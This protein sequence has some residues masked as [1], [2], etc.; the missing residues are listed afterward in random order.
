M[1]FDNLITQS[2]FESLSLE[3]KDALE[4]LNIGVVKETYGDKLHIGGEAWFDGKGIYMMINGK[5]LYELN[6]T[7]KDGF[8]YFRPR[9]RNFIYIGNCNDWKFNW[10]W[11]IFFK[12]WST[13][14]WIWEDGK[15]VSWRKYENGNKV[16]CDDEKIKK[17]VNGR[18]EAEMKR[19]KDEVARRNVTQ[20]NDGQPTQPKVDRVVQGSQV[21]VVS[22]KG[23]EDADPKTD[24]AQKIEDSGELETWDVEEIDKSTFDVLCKGTSLTLTQIKQVVWYANKNS[25]WWLF[26]NGLTSINEWMARELAKFQWYNLMLN[27]LT[28][29]DVD[30]AA[31]LSNFQ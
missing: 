13:Y 25:E 20:G 29:I 15:I 18:I 21:T 16:D 4:E 27:S 28:K 10:E 30:V 24:W 19:H 22:S 3:T 1:T 12:D 14:V 23:W 11:R 6:D 31:Q 9:K 7:N 26:L 17:E 2:E 5:K 8:L